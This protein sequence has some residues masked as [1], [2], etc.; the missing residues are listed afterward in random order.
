MIISDICSIKTSELIENSELIE[1][2][3]DESLVIKKFQEHDEI[4]LRVL[5]NL[6]PSRKKNSLKKTKH[7]LSMQNMNHFDYFSQSMAVLPKAKNMKHQFMRHRPKKNSSFF[8]S[9]QKSNS[10]QTKL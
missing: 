3:N 10:L 5:Q 4:G 2:G 7:L 8:S 6:Q 9:D 1:K